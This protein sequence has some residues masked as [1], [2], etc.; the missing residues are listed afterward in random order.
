MALFAIVGNSFAVSSAEAIN[1][2]EN[3]NHLLFE[4]E[5]TEIYPA[6]LVSHSREKYWVVSVLSGESVSG[7]VPVEDASNAT[8]LNVADG[9][10]A[11]K[12]L[13]QT[14][15]YLRLF[16][17]LKIDFSRQGI[18]V[19]KNT[20]VDFFNSLSNELKNERV[21]LTTIGSE[22]DGYTVLQLM[23]GDLRGQLDRLYP[24]A[25]EIAGQMNEFKEEE[26]VFFSRPDTNS[27]V[28]FVKE[29]DAIYALVEEFDSKRSDYLADMDEF[30]QGI[31]QTD[32]S[33]DSKR[34]L[35]ALASVPPKM[36][37]VS[38]RITNTFNIREKTDE[39]YLSV[40]NQSDNFVQNLE[41]REKRSLA[42]M[43]IY[44]FDEEVVEAT[45]IQGINSV[46][47]I[48]D[49]VLSEDY[50]YQWED[51][52]TLGLLQEKWS[53]TMA[54]YDTGSFESARSF[55]GESKD[56]VLEVF[57]AGLVEPE[58]PIN[59]DL[60]LTGVVLLI[61]LIIILYVLRNRDK[62]AALVKMDDGEEEVLIHE[63]EN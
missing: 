46:K 13:I 51:Q 20:D 14:A 39:V 60:L 33:I 2:V 59:T 8:K 7:F 17:G 49:L 24:L 29:L 28:K 4:G 58:Q 27:L 19:F 47:E 61:V 25:T 6:I 41:L 50:L 35:N 18:W 63:W 22:L 32:L 1:F 23:A 31:A 16:D 11:R 26:A 36:I 15:Q 55:A 40:L 57:E 53:K 44:G 10:L 38:G 5:T 37:E 9:K 52:E 12:R 45:R 42:W 30:K 54:Y 3:T 43:A 48:I 21:D 56:Y 62:F 34:S